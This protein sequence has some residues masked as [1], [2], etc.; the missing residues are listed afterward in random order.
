M[1]QNQLSLLESQ[2][3][4]LQTMWC[5]I[6]IQRS[7]WEMQAWQ[8]QHGE[9]MLLEVLNG[10]HSSASLAWMLDKKHKRVVRELDNLQMLLEYCEELLA[11][12]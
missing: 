1:L 9:D 6:S 7:W 11:E 8:T 4:T 10:L 2:Y 12:L 3:D 5:N